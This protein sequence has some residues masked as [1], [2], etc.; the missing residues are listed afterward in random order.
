M[1]CSWR[2][3]ACPSSARRPRNAAPAAQLF[4][5]GG[6]PALSGVRPVDQGRGIEV[7]ARPCAPS[8]SSPDHGRRMPA[9]TAAPKESLEPQSKP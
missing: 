7:T 9:M 8:A 4:S 2:R 1:L 3:C 6:P 5:R